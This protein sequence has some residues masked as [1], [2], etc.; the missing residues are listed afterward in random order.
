MTALQKAQKTIWWL[1]KIILP[2]SLLVSFLQ[3]L[4][5]ISQIAVLLKPAFSIIG[6]PGES[7]VVFI[8]SMFLPLYAPIAIIA[9]LSLSIREITILAIM[10]LIS[11]NLFVETAI[12]KKTG[13]SFPI[14]FILR[15]VCSVSAAFI[16]NLL[17]PEHLGAAHAAQKALEFSNMGDMLINWIKN[18]GF[19]SLKIALIVSGLMVLQNI[20][21]EFSILSFISKVFAPVMRVLGLSADSSFLWFVAQT[22]GLTYGSAVMIDE[23]ENK[24]ISPE[25]ANL[26]NY[27]IAINHSLLE[28]TLLFVA[29]GVPIGWI[30]IPRIILAM[31]VVWVLR[32]IIKFSV[33]PGNK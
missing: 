2:I 21:K 33:K 27:H 13:S 12:Q 15:L 28:D 1:L 20:L 10:C 32:F 22:L 24:G 3:Y 9:T 19:L 5:I 6:L 8:S 29:I 17:L 16:L 23:V 18:A 14:I 11:H 30:T 31:I 26:L 7:A 4:G 25:N